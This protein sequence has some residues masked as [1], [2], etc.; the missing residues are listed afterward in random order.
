MAPPQTFLTEAVAD[1]T[2]GL[3]SLAVLVMLLLTELLA[4]EPDELA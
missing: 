2:G 3:R 4:E 1:E